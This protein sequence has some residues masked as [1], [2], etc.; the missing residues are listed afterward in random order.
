MR[1]L[2]YFTI[3]F[4][5]LSFNL[6]AQQDEY[7]HCAT[8][9]IYNEIIKSNPEVL[10]EQDK[11]RTYVDNYVKNVQRTEEIYVIPIVFHVVH[12]YGEENI[13]YEQ[14]EDAV[15][16]INRDF[17]KMRE[18]TASIVSE[19]KNIA[20]DCKIEFR[21]ARKDPY[22]N[23]SVGVTRTVSETT[24]GGGDDAKYAAPTWPSDQYLNIWIVNFFG[25]GAAGWA[26]YPGTAPEGLDGIILLHDYVG[27]TGTSNY[28]KGSTI[29]HEIGHYLNLGHPWGHT[30]DPGLSS[31]CEIDDGIADTPNTIGHTSCA[32]SAETCGSLD[33]TQ[34]FMEYSY[35]TRMFTHGQ[36]DEMRA[37]LNYSTA[38][39]NNLH[40]EQN[41]IATG[42]NDDYELELCAPVADFIS[43]KQVGCTG[44]TV[45]Y[46]DLTYGTDYI[47]SRS[48]IFEGGSPE[49]S[50]EEFPVVQ[51][52]TKGTYDV[53][54][55]SYNPTASDSKIRTDYVRIYDINDGYE[56]PYTES[57]E[58]VDFPRITGDDN[59]DFYLTSNGAEPWEQTSYGL[60]N[61]GLRIINKRNPKGTKNLVYLPNLKVTNH[62]EPVYV[63][64]KTA[65]G[66]A[67]DASGDRL[68]VYISSSCGDT[69][70]IVYVATSGILV[71][72]NVPIY[73]TYIPLG[74]D[75]RTHS[76]V[77]NPSKI[78][79]DNLRIVVESVSGGGN[80]LYIDE[81]EF[82]HTNSIKDNFQSELI[83]VYPNPFT[84]EVYIE[85]QTNNGEYTIEIFDHI[86]RKIYETNTDQDVFNASGVF[87]GRSS[88]LYLIKI[89]TVKGTEVMKLNKTF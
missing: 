33:N 71:S 40:T 81:F 7:L 34:N 39:R 45:Q 62:D 75:W 23:C 11:L 44:F 4:T 55:T 76:F 38:G 85:N 57:F 29:T 65:Y 51:Y 16:F 28:G 58:S 59:N 19:F 46:N 64:F 32:L 6:L 67:E 89:R 60:E 66:K 73:G 53:E 77:I 37:V 68:N 31:N 12:N 56:L 80:A 13:S 69:L 86:G 48:W 2:L 17:S 24:Y 49:T 74:S 26:Y 50:I 87:E 21:L 78:T 61:R 35:C 47:E 10:L 43:E 25:N 82:S 20:T 41:L 15:D 42:T 54:L 5:A 1:Q 36:A 22:G 79:S 70:R 72:D 88:G 52:N 30:N 3:I 18:D 9:D 14:I 83:S 84:D 8:D 63:T 27:Y